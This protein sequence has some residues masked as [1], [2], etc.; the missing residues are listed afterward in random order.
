LQNAHRR[1][2]LFVERPPE[3]EKVKRVVKVKEENDDDAQSVDDKTNSK[4]KRQL[5]K[6][7]V[8]SMPANK[9]PRQRKITT[10]DEET[11]VD[12][13]TNSKLKRQLKKASVDSTP[14]N[15]KPRQRK[16]TTSDEETGERD[17][18]V[19]K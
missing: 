10:S 14:A 1:D 2:P 3:K 18:L 16:I 17:G 5:K 6:A 4:L 15:K 13:K 9:K 12:D 7:S 19:D 8:D 11:G